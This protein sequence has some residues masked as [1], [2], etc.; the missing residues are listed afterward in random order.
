MSSVIGLARNG[1]AAFMSWWLA[2]L[3]GLV[4]R[5]LR[6]VARRDRKQVVLL[7]NQQE[8]VVLERNGERARVVGSVATDREDRAARLGALLQRTRRRRQPVTI[9]LSGDLGLRKI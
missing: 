8:T 6:R 3:A 5:Q 2:E 9:C 7:L 1:L 4:P